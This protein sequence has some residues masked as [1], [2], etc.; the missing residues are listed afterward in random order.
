MNETVERTFDA[1]RSNYEA[2]RDLIA[3]D[4]AVL[5]ADIGL[6]EARDE[7]S[8]A[9]SR[10]FAALRAKDDALRAKDDVL[11]NHIVKMDL[12]SRSDQ[13]KDNQT[14]SEAFDQYMRHGSAGVNDSAYIQGVTGDFVWRYDDTQVA[15]VFAAMPEM[16]ATIVNG[17]VVN[18]PSVRPGAGW[19]TG[20][21]GTL[22]RTLKSNAG[23]RDACYVFTTPDGN[24]LNQPNMD[25]TAEGDVVAEN[26][27]TPVS[28][29]TQTW[30][31]VTYKRQTYRSQKINIPNPTGR[32]APFNMD[33]EIGIT[34]GMQIGRAQ[35]TDFTKGKTGS[36][37]EHLANG[38]VTE[39]SGTGATTA[40][41]SRRI[42]GI[43]ADQIVDLLI[44]LQR[45]IDPQYL[46][47][48]YSQGAFDPRSG[49][50]PGGGVGWM[51]NNETWLIFD[52]TLVKDDK[53]AV[54]SPDQTFFSGLPVQ[55]FRRMPV[56]INQACD[57]PT[58]SNDSFGTNDL[59]WAL[60]NWQLGYGIR[61]IGTIRI[62]RDPYGTAGDN[63]QYTLMAFAEAD[64]RARGA[65]KAGNTEAIRMRLAAGT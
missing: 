12:G 8:D 9:E 58:G 7:L 61:D 36:V 15:Q 52:S 65:I 56:F 16:N 10:Q 6:L 49:S 5:A 46:G 40:G 60:G 59:M 32:D 24:D 14:Q 44:G 55:M 19:E 42:G 11:A 53:T 43:T 62:H 4:R 13:G 3:A 64:G 30:D 33:A 37:V 47:A 45:E 28:D 21:I 51:M 20:V 48:T 35:N 26:A 29:T 54:L 34:L 31:L 38:V 17:Q 27:N 2:D 39:R 25:N 22:L 63:N 23:M 18:A 57:A 41:T 1:Q 50:V